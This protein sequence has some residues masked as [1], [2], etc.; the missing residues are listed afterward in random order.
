LRDSGFLQPEEVLH[1]VVKFFDCD[2]DEKL[3]YTEFLS[4]VLPCDHAKL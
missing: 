3:N 2:H 4:L 1:F